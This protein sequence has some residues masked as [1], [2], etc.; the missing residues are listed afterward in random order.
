MRCATRIGAHATQDFAN[1]KG[2]S[3]LRC[4]CTTLQFIQLQ[5]F[6]MSSTTVSQDERTGALVTYLLT[7]FLGIIGAVIGW[8][9]FKDKG[10]FAKDQP[11][12]ARNW[13]ITATIAYIAIWILVTILIMVVSPNA[14]FSLLALI[15]PLA[16]FVLSII[17]AIKSNGGNAY[18]YPFV[19]R[20]VK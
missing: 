12:E 11:S 3:G 18:R 5:G 19:L 16:N 8:A 10:P 2:N 6:S 20:L 4:A 13:A 1:A 7:A 17:G 14:L 9:I 15:V